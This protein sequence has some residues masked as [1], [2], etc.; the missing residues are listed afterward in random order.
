MPEATLSLL[1][2]ARDRWSPATADARALQSPNKST[3]VAATYFDAQQIRAKLSFSKAFTGNIE[4]YALDWDKRGRR[5]TI[6]V[7]N[8]TALLSSD[9]SAGAWVAFPVSVGAGGSASVTVDQ[10]AGVNAV[11]SG[12]FLE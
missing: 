10:S 6:T 7:N 8:Q 5:E 2:G 12:I 3:R 1:E 11:L 4:L 9:F